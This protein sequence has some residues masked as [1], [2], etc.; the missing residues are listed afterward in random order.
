M[1]QF[2]RILGNYILIGLLMISSFSGSFL[3]LIFSNAIVGSDICSHKEHQDV[4]LLQ[5]IPDIA[6]DTSL[7]KTVHFF[8]YW[9]SLKPQLNT[10]IFLDCFPFL[11]NASHKKGRQFYRLFLLFH[12]LKIALF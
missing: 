6:G 10:F 1:K 4:F 2:Y 8:N 12:C 3:S 11:S 9:S 7:Q 5:T